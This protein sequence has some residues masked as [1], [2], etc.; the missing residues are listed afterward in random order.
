MCTLSVGG[1]GWGIELYN[2]RGVYMYTPRVGVGEYVYTYLVMSL[3]GQWSSDENVRTRT[4]I[5]M[6]LIYVIS[7]HAIISKSI[8]L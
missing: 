7:N 2:T 5:G 3:K 8:E 1:R 4:Y 6:Q